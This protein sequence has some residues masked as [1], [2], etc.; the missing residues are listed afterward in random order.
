[1]LSAGIIPVALGDDGAPSFLVLRAYRYWD[2]PKGVVEAGEDAFQAAQRELAEETGLRADGFPWGETFHETPPYAKGKVARYYLARV[3]RVD[4]VLPVSPELGRP[5]HH[6]ARWV[7]ADEGL[8][9]L[10][11]RVADALRWALRQIG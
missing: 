5:E 7:D 11:E 4:V 6:E 8:R 2:F 10:N 1:M 9:L 3:T